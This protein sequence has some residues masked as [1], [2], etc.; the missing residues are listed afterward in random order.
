MFEEK[1]NVMISKTE[2]SQS[3]VKSLS[4]QIKMLSDENVY[5]RQKVTG[6]E[7][8]IPKSTTSIFAI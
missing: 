3:E 4:N 6:L 1:L 5:L 7:D 8:Y 2:D